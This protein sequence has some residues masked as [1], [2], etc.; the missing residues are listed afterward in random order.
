MSQKRFGRDWSQR[1]DRRRGHGAYVVL[2]VVREKLE[3]VG[4]KE[5]GERDRWR[6]GDGEGEGEG[7][8]GEETV[9]E[10]KRQRL[11]FIRL[12]FLT[13]KGMGCGESSVGCKKVCGDHAPDRDMRRQQKRKQKGGQGKRRRK[14]KRK[15]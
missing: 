8:T 3:S 4:E 9:A 2:F 15:R 7:K 6:D 11:F 13:C 14:R 1:D 10:A 5:T 12:F